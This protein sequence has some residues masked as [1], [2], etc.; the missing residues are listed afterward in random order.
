MRTER[1]EARSLM[2]GHRIL[3]NGRWRRVRVAQSVARGEGAMARREIT[4]VVGECQNQ[5]MLRFEPCQLVEID[6]ENAP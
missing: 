5:E 3:H 4:V 6:P 2:E 1:L